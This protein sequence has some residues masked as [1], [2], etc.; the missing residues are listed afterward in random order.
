MEQGDAAAPV[1]PRAVTHCLVPTRSM[2][3]YPG[4]AVD[5]ALQRFVVARKAKTEAVLTMLR[6]HLTWFKEQDIRGLRGSTPQVVLG[7][8]SDTV[9]E[10]N[11]SFPHYFAGHDLE[12]RP[13][14]YIY[15]V[16]YAASHLFSLVPPERV[17]R[18]HTWRTERMLDAMYTRLQSGAQPAPTGQVS[19][20]IDLSGMTMRH[21]DKQFL[22]LIKLLSVV[23]QAHY[24]ERLGKMHICGVS[25]IFFVVW[26]MVRPW[27]DARTASKISF[28]T[29]D[30][31]E[32]GALL[33]FID[34]AQL[35]RAY[36]GD[37][38][39]P[40][41]TT[42]DST[43]AEDD[44]AA[45][46]PP[47]TQLVGAHT[48]DL[49]ISSASSA[50]RVTP[51]LQAQMSGR[52]AGRR[53][54]G[55]GWSSTGGA[56]VHV[57]SP[58][59][60]P[61]RPSR[62]PP[63]HDDLL[64]GGQSI[65]GPEGAAAGALHSRS[66]SADFA[67]AL[68]RRGGHKRNGSDDAASVMSFLSSGASSMYDDAESEF[69]DAVDA[70][71][72][73]RLAEVED[74]DTLAP[75]DGSSHPDADA[76]AVVNKVLSSPPHH[77]QEGSQGESSSFSRPQ[78]L[79]IRAPGRNKR[80]SGPASLFPHG[81]GQKGRPP[82][83]PSIPEVKAVKTRLNRVRLLLD[84]T[85]IFTLVTSI[86]LLSLND[87]GSTAHPLAGASLRAFGGVILSVSVMSLLL[88]LTVVWSAGSIC[89]TV[90]EFLCRRKADADEEDAEANV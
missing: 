71:V 65:Q 34:G 53:R 74:A 60:S 83:L 37:A 39:N 81:G 32:R 43:A 8:A 25:R 40:W 14:T 35:P 50:G 2:L 68:H 51:P 4:E 67:L 72:D 20:V 90:R 3:A 29:S 15:G 73:L 57:T 82:S 63:V 13:V 36:G 88:G 56:E 12:G 52:Q 48:V 54:G 79:P 30:E 17:A 87:S 21:V 28:L 42:T 41:D 6:A 7:V 84:C 47:P 44:A 89:Y 11:A 61:V 76:I 10:V 70:Y 80:G 55:S 66:A 31:V 9:A 85:N 19:V 24:P 58:S 16:S 5:T 18:Y 33:Q 46:Q 78:T 27:L 64:L 49:R 62:A 38:P 75:S 45:M 69:L 86:V 1:C 22:A 26:R 77:H 59:A 23:D